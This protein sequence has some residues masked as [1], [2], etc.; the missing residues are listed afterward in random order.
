[1]VQD[2]RKFLVTSDYPMDFIVWSTN[3]NFSAN[4]HEQKTLKI[5]HGLPF[6]PLLFGIYSSD[7]GATWQA[8]GAEAG[9]DA[10]VFWTFIDSDTTN[11][12]VTIWARNVAVSIIFKIWAFAPSGTEATLAVP[13]TESIFH[14]NV[15]YNY[16]KLAHTGEWTASVGNNVVL[17][18][19]NL[20]YIP[21]AMVWFEYESGEI[22]DCFSQVSSN[23]TKRANHSIGLDETALYANFSDLNIGGDYGNISK[24]HY[25]IYADEVGGQA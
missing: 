7:N 20:G 15:D 13:A 1:M 16:S 19:H 10:G 8:F 22:E 12:T 24:V 11:A 18:N 4:A 17:C 6:T 9:T 14:L 5:P 25:R 23:T 21:R 3:G 2:A